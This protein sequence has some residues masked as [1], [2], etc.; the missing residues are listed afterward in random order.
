MLKS[1]W[2]S[3]AKH[4]LPFAV[5]YAPGASCVFNNKEKSPTVNDWADN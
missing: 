1:C 4:L 2:G 3:S 5:D